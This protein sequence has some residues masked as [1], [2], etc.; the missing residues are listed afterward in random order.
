MNE[1]EIVINCIKKGAIPPL[2][3]D[4][5]LV[6]EGVCGV[7][8]GFCYLLVSDGWMDELNTDETM[9]GMSQRSAAPNR[10]F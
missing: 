3:C 5:T 7:L 2:E 1:I 6:R 8:G 9:H 4:D 10:T